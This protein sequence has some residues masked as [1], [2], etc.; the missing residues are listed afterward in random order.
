MLHD[1]QEFLLR[2]QS[3]HLADRAECSFVQE[4]YNE[5]RLG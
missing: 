5:N 2:M 4:G 1:R 3:R